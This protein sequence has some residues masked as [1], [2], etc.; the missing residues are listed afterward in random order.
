M[1]SSL[2]ARDLATGA[3]FAAL[4]AAG[5]LVALPM[6]GPVPFTLQVAFVLL[7]GLLLG[8]RLATMSVVVYLIAGLVAPVYAQG[9]SGLGV[10]VGPTGGYLVGFAVAACL[11]GWLTERFQPR[12]F[13][14]LLGI[15][16]A[17]LLPIY[18]IGATWLALQLHTT[19]IQAVVW[20]GV[21]QFL[22]ADAAKAALAAVAARALLSLP[23]DLRGLSRAR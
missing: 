3:L 18:A 2:S 22:P 5:A 10:L 11:V 13:M 23:L 7:A 12:R 17:G 15:A 1:R 8:A 4:I 6:F 19:S 20:G 16:L 14:P 21:L 9:T